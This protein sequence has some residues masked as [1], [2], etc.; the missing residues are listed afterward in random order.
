MMKN[1]LLLLTFVVFNQHQSFAHAKSRGA[2]FSKD[3]MA[4]ER[5]QDSRR[6]LESRRLM[7]SL[8]GGGGA[9]NAVR[10]MAKTQKQMTRPGDETDV[11]ATTAP[12]SA[13]D[14]AAP[15]VSETPAPMVPA[16]VTPFVPETPAPVVSA[17]PAPVVSA[18]PA[19]VVSATPAPV[20]SPEVP[21]VPATAVPSTDQ[22]FINLI[23]KPTF[24]PTP[25]HIDTGRACPTPD[26]LPW[27]ALA[28]NSPLLQSCDV[29]SDC[30]EYFPEDGPSCCSWP[31]CVCATVYPGHEAEFKCVNF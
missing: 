20:V 22:P 1:S 29:D 18:T 19:P 3:S 25:P 12:A 15:A 10:G 9:G 28:D 26:S 24:M 31:F 17:T 16:T 6:E 23:V 11:V 7:L 21:V 5:F 8:S 13:P 2:Y 27:Q 30:A 14:T 4:R